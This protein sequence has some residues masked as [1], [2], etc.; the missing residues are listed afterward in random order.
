[1]QVLLL[2]SNSK[3]C[4][5]LDQASRT[6]AQVLNK[7]MSNVTIGSGLHLVEMTP[8]ADP[9]VRDG[10]GAASTPAVGKNPPRGRARATALP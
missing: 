10:N 4:G 8:D 6:R 3:W 7:V 5:D 2:S 1:M 9:L